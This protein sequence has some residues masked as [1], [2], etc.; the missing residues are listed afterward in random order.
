MEANIL[1]FQRPYAVKFERLDVDDMAAL[2]TSRKGSDTYYIT[3]VDDGECEEIYIR[4]GDRV[5]QQHEFT[6]EEREHGNR[7]IRAAA[8][9]HSEQLSTWQGLTF[10]ERL[11]LLVQWGHDTMNQ[12]KEAAEA[13]AACD[14]LEHRQEIAELCK[15]MDQQES[16]LSAL[17]TVRSLL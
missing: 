8:V 10:S 13:A 4:H 12:L 2:F 9:I 3:L 11:S 15:D 7:L 16:Y 5:S 1:P 17:A 14:A 6:P